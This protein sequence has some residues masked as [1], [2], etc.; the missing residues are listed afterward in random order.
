VC[1]GDAER[2]LTA[3]ARRTQSPAQD[4]LEGATELGVEDGVD[5]RVEEAVDVAEP[6]EQREQPR[7]HVAQ[8]RR[9]PGRRARRH[10]TSASGG[11]EQV[12]AQTDGVDDVDGEER[13]PA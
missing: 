2:P 1:S 12:V 5:D 9:P 6:D 4:A 8:A 13:R 11:D 3:A 10:V 7:L